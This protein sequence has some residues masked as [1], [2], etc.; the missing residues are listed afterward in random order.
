LAT[1]SAIVWGYFYNAF[2]KDSYLS[3]TDKE[4]I[5]IYKAT[6]F[7]TEAVPWL[8]DRWMAIKVPIMKQF[9]KDYV[10][11]NHESLPQ[12]KRSEALTKFILSLSDQQLVTG[13]AILIASLSNRCRVSLYEFRVLVSLAWFSSTTHQ[14]TLRVLQHYLFT[15][16]VVRNWRI[17][18]MV[19]LM[20]MLIF[21]LIAQTGSAPQ[22]T[23]LQCGISNISGLYPLGPSQEFGNQPGLLNMIVICIQLLSTYGRLVYDLFGKTKGPGRSIAEEIAKRITMRRMADRYQDVKHGFNAET[24]SVE[25]EA[26]WEDVKKEAYIHAYLQCFWADTASKRDFLSH[27]FYSIP[28]E[29]AFFL[30][31]LQEPP[32]QWTGRSW[33]PG[34]EMM[35]LCYQGSFL[36]KLPPMLFDLAFGISQ[37]VSSRW[38]YAPKLGEASNRM[39]FGQIVPLFLLSLP[40]LVAAEIY[41][42]EL[43]CNS[44]RSC[45]N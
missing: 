43:S 23:A 4:V 27:S 35:I 28:S 8:Y 17:F 12:E 36:S 22:T 3:E 16:K 33:G 19:C 37:V 6:K 21:G 32:C 18:A 34:L 40:M 41:Y 14:S 30:A 2:P 9:S 26:V 44:L 39:D 24:K 15:N 13:L 45:F 1:I 31:V 42:G 20:I 29:R 10:M 25:I 7:S 38:Q 11:H 5:S